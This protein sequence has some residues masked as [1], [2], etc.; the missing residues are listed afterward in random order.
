MGKAN[1]K[2]TVRKR[3][4]ACGHK[5]GID[6]TTVNRRATRRN[7][8]AIGGKEDEEFDGIHVAHSFL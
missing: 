1:K 2:A 4:V 5:T 6:L 7:N 8:F 3:T